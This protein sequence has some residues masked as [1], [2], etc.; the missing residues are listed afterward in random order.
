MYVIGYI[1]TVRYLVVL[2]IMFIKNN[3]LKRFVIVFVFLI[4]F[5]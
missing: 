3:M 4:N 2:M 5:R 1:R